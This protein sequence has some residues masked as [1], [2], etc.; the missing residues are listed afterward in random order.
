MEYV[1]YSDYIGS[2]AARITIPIKELSF[3]ESDPVGFWFA[4]IGAVTALVG[5]IVG[6]SC[7]EKIKDKIS[8]LIEKRKKSKVREIEQEQ[9]PTQYVDE[10]KW[11]EN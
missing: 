2:N 10:H 7:W 8:Q 11:Y 4:V 6:F 5:M 1:G 9:E 3:M